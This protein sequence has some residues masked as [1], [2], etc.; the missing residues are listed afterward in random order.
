MIVEQIPP[1][2]SLMF[3]LGCHLYNSWKGCLL[4]QIIFWDCKASLD[5]REGASQGAAEYVVHSLFLN[6]ESPGIGELEL[7]SCIHL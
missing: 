5:Y 6:L 2:Q 3:H 4:E 7:P 1:P